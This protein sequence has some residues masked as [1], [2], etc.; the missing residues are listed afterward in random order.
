MDPGRQRKVLDR[1]GLWHGCAEG[2]N[3]KNSSLV[4][5]LVA[6]RTSPTARKASKEDRSASLSAVTVIP[7][8]RCS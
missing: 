1:L 7:G 2:E 6:T 3:S 4:V 8:E 5:V